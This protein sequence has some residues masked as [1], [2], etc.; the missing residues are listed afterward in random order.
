M[1]I[2]NHKA[3]TA[4]TCYKKTNQFCPGYS[5]MQISTTWYH[6]IDKIVTYVFSEDYYKFYITIAPSVNYYLAHITYLKS[7][8][9]I[10]S[11]ENLHE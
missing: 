6:E 4:C 8:L 5:T 1:Y 2:C 7:M 9:N 11:Y 3:T 10:N